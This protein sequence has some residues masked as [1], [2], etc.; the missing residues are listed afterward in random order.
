MTP[1]SLLCRVV[2]RPRAIQIQF[3]GRPLAATVGSLLL[4]AASAAGA[5]PVPFT[6]PTIGSANTAVADPPVARPHNTPCKVNLFT[7]Q[8]FADFSPKLFNYSP[9]AA[10]P[11]PWRKVVL[12]ADYSVEAGRQFD[13]TATL[14]IGGANIYFGTTAEP[15]HAVGRAWHIERDLTEYSALLAQPSTARAELGNLVNSTYTSSLWGSAALSFYPLEQDG[16]DASAPKVADR[17]LP[18]SAGVTGGT[19]ALFSPSDPLSA[20]FKLP[21][22]I[23]RAVLDVVLQHQGANDEFWYACVPAAL[24]APLQSCTGTAF[25]EGELTIDGQPAGVVPIRPWIFTG[26][27]DPLL[28]RPI[29]SPQALNFEPYRVDVTPFAANLSDGQPHTFAIT[30]FNDSQYFQ[31]TANLLLW[32]DHGSTQVTGGVTENTIGAPAPVVTSDLTTDAV[33]TLSGTVGTSSAREFVLGGRVVT[34]HGTV[35][36]EIRQKITFD[37]QQQFVVPTTALDYVQNITQSTE[38]RSTTVVRGGGDER[39]TVSHLSWPLVLDITVHPDSSFAT[40]VS[41][42]YIEDIRSPQGNRLVSN[43]GQAHD[44]YPSGAGQVG[45][46]HYLSRDGEGHCYSR[47]LDAAGGVLTAIVDGQGCHAD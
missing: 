2:A 16:D 10:C 26:G 22:N 24:S 36:T 11:G 6:P 5:Q 15:S 1:T 13:R 12:E 45:E 47:V 25:R 21:T 29:P 42:S 20:T 19:V 7:A 18:L 34:S 39:E 8:Q 38:I 31:T 33:G 3:H 17:V 32:L 40:T 23:E 37:N 30:V 9:P 43:S 4:V 46:Q 35:D 41:Q 44:N 27:V 14:W 28:W